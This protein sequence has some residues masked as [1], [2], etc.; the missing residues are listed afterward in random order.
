M[1][2]IRC[3]KPPNQYVADAL[4][5][6][7]VRYKD[8]AAEYLPERFND[9]TKEYDDIVCHLCG[10]TECRWFKEYVPRYGPSSYRLTIVRHGRS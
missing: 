9:L 8:M 1:P 6:D 4:Y 7:R 5:K 10:D 2:D 3:L